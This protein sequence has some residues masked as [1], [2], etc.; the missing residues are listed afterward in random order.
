V[1]ADLK[2]EYAVNNTS[3]ERVEYDRDIY[4]KIYAQG[5]TVGTEENPETLEVV[6]DAPPAV[7]DAYR[8]PRYG[9]ID[10]GDVTSTAT[11]TYMAEQ[12]L[13]LQERARVI[14]TLSVAELKR[15]SSPPAGDWDIEIGRAV[16][17]KD[18]DL[19]IDVFRHIISYRY[20]PLKPESPSEVSVGGRIN[21]LYLFRRVEDAE[22]QFGGRPSRVVPESVEVNVTSDDAE[23]L[24][25]LRGFVSSSDPVFSRG[26][27]NNLWFKY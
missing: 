15:L 5:G 24:D 25:V 18:T 13:D 26:E 16:N 10:F 7:V 21:Y 6:V 12:Y 20:N 3:I 11:L 17:V 23:P 14:Y 27:E 1:A 8:W 4:T 9:Y 2:L 22:I 19:G